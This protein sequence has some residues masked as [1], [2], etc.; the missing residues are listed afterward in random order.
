MG[1]LIYAGDCVRLTVAVPCSPWGGFCD[2][3][4]FCTVI[5]SLEGVSSGRFLFP[6][7][8]ALPLEFCR[9]NSI[10]SS[11][12]CAGNADHAGLISSFPQD[13]SVPLAARGSDVSVQAWPGSLWPVLLN[14]ESLPSSLQCVSAGELDWQQKLVGWEVF[15]SSVVLVSCR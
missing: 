10:V 15:P 12:C 7:C 9:D 8:S 2:P 11:V 6:G 13:S 1:G 4:P 3:C 5:N 14:P